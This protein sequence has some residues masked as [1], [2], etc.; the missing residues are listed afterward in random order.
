MLGDVFVVCEPESRGM[1]ELRASL[2][3]MFPGCVPK[4]VAM[5]SSQSVSMV[6]IAR[7]FMT[8]LW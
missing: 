4:L 3:M 5:L 1:K 8:G 6:E 7:V 2:D